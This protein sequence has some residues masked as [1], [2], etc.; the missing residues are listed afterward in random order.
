[1]A[2]VTTAPVPDARFA[3]ATL[4]VHCFLDACA[5]V[6]PVAPGQRI[7]SAQEGITCTTTS[8]VAVVGH[9]ER[10]VYCRVEQPNV[11]TYSFDGAKFDCVGSRLGCHNVMMVDTTNGR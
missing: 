7:Y 10:F 6:Q 4:S 8:S 5:G 9:R 2:R 3:T 11:F 1:M